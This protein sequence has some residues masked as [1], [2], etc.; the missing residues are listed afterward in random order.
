MEEITNSDKFKSFCP[1]C[2]SNNTINLDKFNSQALINLY[3][4]EYAFD[5]SYLMKGVKEI[6]IKKCN[7]CA[8]KYFYP[9]IV[10]DDK[11]Y[12]RLQQ[13]E[14]YYYN[15]KFEYQIVKKYFTNEKDVL[16]IGAGK[17][18]FSKII[19]KKTYTGLELSNSAVK[20]AQKEDIT[21]YNQKIQDFAANNINKK[22]DIII[23]FQVLEHVS[24][25]ELRSF[26]DS[27]L[28]LLKKGGKFIVCV[29]SDSSFVG[30]MPNA[31]LNL[32]PHHITRW[33]DETFQKMEELFPLKTI[34][35]YYEPLKPCNYN[36]FIIH[37]LSNFLR[38]RNK[39]TQNK[40]IKHKV[41]SRIIRHIPQKLKQHYIKNKNY[42]GHSVIVVYEKK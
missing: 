7:N 8:L 37:K 3:K 2:N 16:E 15:D 23:S 36:A 27:S 22:F 20:I 11:F 40:R 13:L 17:G 38:I 41:I 35:T 29:P 14:N 28:Q 33:P 30:G 42:R 24:L 5:I 32:P 4:N 26:I 6:D 19:P 34:A 25:H 21:L 1:L 39:A 12:K 10:G 9:N 31:T 18:A